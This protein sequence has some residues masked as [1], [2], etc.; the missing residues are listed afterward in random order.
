MVSQDSLI[1]SYVECGEPHIF[2]RYIFSFCVCLYFCPFFLQVYSSLAL[3]QMSCKYFSS[4]CWLLT[5][6]RV[7]FC[8]AKTPDV[9]GVEFIHPLFYFD[10]GFC[11]IVWKAFLTLSLKKLKKK[12]TSHGLVFKKKNSPPRPRP[13]HRAFFDLSSLTRD[14]TTLPPALE[15]WS[16]N[17]WTPKEVPILYYF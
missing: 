12:K 6:P 5:L 16:L 9:Y 1:C 4:V 8:H 3:C 2:K 15:A 17:Y 13:R 7:L 14:P 10:S 11:V